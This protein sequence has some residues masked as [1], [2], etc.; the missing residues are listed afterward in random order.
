MLLPNTHTLVLIRKTKRKKVFTSVKALFYS[1]LLPQACSIHPVAVSV[2]FHSPE[3][4]GLS[5]ILMKNQEAPLQMFCCSHLTH[6]WDPSNQSSQL[7][8]KSHHFPS[9]HTD[10]CL[11][12]L[13]AHQCDFT[14]TR[15]NLCRDKVSFFCLNLE[16]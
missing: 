5:S 15:Q 16:A 9:S 10:L 1:L 8:L 2:V 3:D 14:L 11:I 6:R 7:P 4:E 13:K 12:Y